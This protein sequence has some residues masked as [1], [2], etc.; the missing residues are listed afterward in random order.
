LMG[1]GGLSWRRFLVPIVAANLVISLIYAAFG[2]YFRERDALLT[3][4]VFSGTV[5][6]AIAL[7]V[8]QR[9]RKER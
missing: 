3:A 1:A 4:V 9:W 7:I 2:E 6:L 8:R 5:P